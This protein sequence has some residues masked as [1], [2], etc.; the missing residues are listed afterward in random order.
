MTS[1]LESIESTQ[2]PPD[3][4]RVLVIRA[5]LYS[6]TTPKLRET[7]RVLAHAFA[8]RS[9]AQVRSCAEARILT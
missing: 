8:T 7:L 6:S 3:I 1:P 2:Q 5:T 9:E 4:V